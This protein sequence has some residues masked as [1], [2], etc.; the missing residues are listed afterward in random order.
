MSMVMWPMSVTVALKPECTN[1]NL[2]NG[3]LYNVLELGS[4]YEKIACEVDIKD[5]LETFV[6]N[7][8][9]VHTLLK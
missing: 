5:P 6:N 7:S 8:L 4:A 2:I 1:S 9:C 3:C